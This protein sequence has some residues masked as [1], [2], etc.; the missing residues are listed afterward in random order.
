[1]AHSPELTAERPD[2]AQSS[3][4]LK[5][6][7]LLRHQCLIGGEWVSADGGTSWNRAGGATPAVLDRPGTQR[8]DSNALACE[9]NRKLAA[10]RQHGAFRRRI[11]DL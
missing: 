5:D 9:L 11:G 10:H 1:M 8:V 7:G 6:Q 4:K 2:T 3:L